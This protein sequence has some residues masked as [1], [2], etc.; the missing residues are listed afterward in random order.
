[1]KRG[2]ALKWIELL[3]SGNYKFN[4]GSSL[5]WAD[6]TFDGLG[7]LEDFVSNGDWKLLSHAGCYANRD[8]SIGFL[9]KYVKEKCKIKTDIFPRLL[10][11]SNVLYYYDN[12]NDI[13]N[14]HIFCGWVEMNYEE[15]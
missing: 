7:V 9:S 5:R 10:A 15:L 6:N 12:L 11:S 14:L 3:Q 4:D 1:M 13:D 2:S 8:G